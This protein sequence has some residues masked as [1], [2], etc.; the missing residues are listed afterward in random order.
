[1]FR[2]AVTTFKE[3]LK[4]A[5]ESDKVLYYLGALYQQLDEFD[6]AISYYNRIDKESDLYFDSNLQISK[7]L[8]ALVT[9]RGESDEL[10]SRIDTFIRKISEI[11]GDRAEM[12][13]NSFIFAKA[14]FYGSKKII[15]MRLFDK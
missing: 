6:L 15:M 14:Y 4:V 1:M 2:K 9:V 5:P 7:L 12:V 3:I 10:L 8:R 11:K 13:K